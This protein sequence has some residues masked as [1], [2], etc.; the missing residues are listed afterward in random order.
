METREFERATINGW[1]AL[2]GQ[3]LAGVGL[4][5]L[6]K[7]T[8]LGHE[9]NV[10]LVILDALLSA[11]WTLLWFGFFTLQPNV[12]AVLIL[13]GH[14]TGTVKRSGFHWANPFLSKKKVSL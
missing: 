14:Y 7:S 1:V 2:A 12:A 9:N 11:V 8:L 6:W 5:A 4:A 3:F 10:A 13:F